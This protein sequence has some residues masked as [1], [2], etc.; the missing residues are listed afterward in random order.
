MAV[1]I[2]SDSASGDS[3]LDLRRATVLGVVLAAHV[4][5]IFVIGR[6]VRHREADRDIIYVPLPITPDEEPQP[7]F[8]PQPPDARETRT[9]A[10]ELSLVPPSQAEVTPLVPEEPAA[11]VDWHA[12]AQKSAEA[13]EHRERAKREQRS[14]DFPQAGMKAPRS[15]P[16]C[17]F[18]QCEPGW[19]AAPS[20]FPSSKRGRIEKTADG[21]V[22]HWTSNN[23]YQI[24]VTPNIFHRGMN[25]CVASLD[26]KSARGDLF[27]HMNDVPPPEE[28]AFDVP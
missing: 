9:R 28:R 19:G 1:P 3:R 10:Q 15:K 20:V 6:A 14:F 13:Y 4:A 22:I 24:L 27:D 21:E 16:K 11:P 5:M 8:V 17:P 25:K 26:K 2:A 7:P 18:E 23:C 12:E